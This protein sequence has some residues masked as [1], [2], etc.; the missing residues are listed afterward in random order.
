MLLRIASHLYWMGRY[1]ERMEN[2]ARTVEALYLTSS[3]AKGSS[4][5]DLEWENLLA[6]TGR[7][8]DFLARHGA[9]SSTKLL[10]FILLDL[11]NPSSLLTS[12]RTA[13]ENGRAVCGT[14]SPEMWEMLNTLWLDLREIDPAHLMIE[15]VGP[16]LDRVKEGA[17]LFRGTLERTLPQDD[18]VRLIGLGTVI[19]RADHTAR[20]LIA[21]FPSLLK[22]TEREAHYDA[23]LKV[24]RSVGAAAAYRKLYRDG[25]TPGQVVELLV[26]RNE[27]PASLHACLDRVND[28]LKPLSRGIGPE[29]VR[30]AADLHLLLHDD[31]IGVILRHTLH[32]Y[33]IDFTQGLQALSTEIDRAL[34]TPICA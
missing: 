29:A 16:L 30:L 11:E 23:S 33:L 8:D 18:T 10:R 14:L 31:Q 22:D 9:I 6:M 21:R 17:H 20:I 1:I 32:E 19:E 3:I 26:L 27:I 2:T 13:R 28:L 34:R 5:S 4:S 7:R 24:L 15:G 12:L 25:I